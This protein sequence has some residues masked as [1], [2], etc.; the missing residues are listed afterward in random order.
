MTNKPC[1]VSLRIRILIS[2]IFSYFRYRFR[3]KCNLVSTLHLI[4][5]PHLRLYTEVRR[6]SSN[7]PRLNCAKL[8]CSLHPPAG[9][10]RKI[11][12]LTTPTRTSSHPAQLT[13][14]HALSTTAPPPVS[15][16]ALLLPAPSIAA[17]H[18]PCTVPDPQLRLQAKTSS[19][20]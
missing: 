15:P 10:T 7:A 19:S 14:P 13:L 20:F 8:A 3:M 1:F 4:S 11:T 6:S 5:D 2:H 12:L 18:V 9:C 16:I 17:L